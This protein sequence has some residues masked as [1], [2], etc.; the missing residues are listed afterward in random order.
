MMI[1]RFSLLGKWLEIIQLSI[2]SK[3]WLALGFCRV[4]A[5]T[6]TKTFNLTWASGV[7][8][9]HWHWDVLDLVT[10]DIFFVP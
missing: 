9:S 7:V 6:S 1:L 8:F 4:V 5:A 3:N 2:H 10:E